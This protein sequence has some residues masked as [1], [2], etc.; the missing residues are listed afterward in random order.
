[1]N[2]WLDQGVPKDHILPGNAKDNFWG[3][4]YLL[5]ALLSF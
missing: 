1:M 3:L 5:A 4:Y 2:Y